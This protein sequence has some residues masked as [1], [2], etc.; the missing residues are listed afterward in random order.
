MDDRAALGALVPDPVKHGLYHSITAYSVELVEIGCAAFG[1][2]IKVFA[3]HSVGTVKTRLYHGIA[4][5]NHEA[6]ANLHLDGNSY[7]DPDGEPD[8]HVDARAHRYP[9]PDADGD[10][11]PEAYGDV[12]ADSRAHRYV[13][14]GH[15]HPGDRGPP[16]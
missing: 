15:R 14:S 13:D 7:R 12:D 10:P 6:I 3:Q 5:A 4:H 16:P 8:P 9:D 11:H 2:G 1:A